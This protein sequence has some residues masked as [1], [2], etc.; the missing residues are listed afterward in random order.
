MTDELM[1]ALDDCLRA[2]EAGYALEAALARHPQLA[3]ELRPLLMAAQT[4]RPL[5]PI[6]VPR[7][8]EDASRVRYLARARA[9]RSAP[10]PGQAFLSSLTFAARL[11]LIVLIVFIAGLGV[12]TA[13]AQALPGDAL[14][15]LKRAVEQVQLNVAP[16]DARAAL[17]QAIE[18]RRVQETRAVLAQGRTV[19]V[20]FTG[21]VEQMAG[22]RWIIRGFIVL[23]P[24]NLQTGIALGD[25]VTVFGLAQPEGLIRAARL[26]KR[27]EAAPL[28]PT[29][30]PRPTSTLAFSA[31][32]I[33]ITVTEAPED[34]EAPE[35]TTTPGSGGRGPSPSDTP[36]PT[37]T[38]G[39]GS[40][41]SPS[42]T[43]QPPTPGGGS[44]PSPSNTPQP[45]ETPR[46]TDDDETDEPDEEEFKGTVEAI[47]G[48]WMISG[49]AVVITA[50]TEI[51][52]NPQVGDRV[53]VKAWRLNDGTL[54]ARRIEKED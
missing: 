3:D 8:S 7:Q 20:E 46:P 42:N 4:A 18:E 48:T 15:G 22:E 17:E 13:S 45:S 49:R 9:L 5:T 27:D 28:P 36:R 2:M 50:E 14:Y 26:E 21:R 44:G 41:P 39:S 16:A 31:T 54:V 29:E 37:S 38:P 30:T 47:G 53:E 24:L 52:N 6:R 35:S 12:V 23:V 32:P 34:T 33:P 19:E 10:R 51:R 40:G 25:K 1:L 11:A 43:P